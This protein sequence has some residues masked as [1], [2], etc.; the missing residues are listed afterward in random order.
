MQS[1]NTKRVPVIEPIKT[2]TSAW[3]WVAMQRG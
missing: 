1:E 2:V 3:V